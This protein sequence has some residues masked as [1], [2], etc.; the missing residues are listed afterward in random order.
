MAITSRR[1]LAKSTAS[2][3]RLLIKILELN[4]IRGVV[5]HYQ[6]ISSVLLCITSKYIQIVSK[7]KM[8]LKN[9]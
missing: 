6:A 7:R 2:I 5:L 8:I 1:S 3:Y 4:D 9:I